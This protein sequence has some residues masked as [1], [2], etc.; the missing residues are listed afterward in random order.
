MSY[1]LKINEVNLTKNEIIRKWMISSVIH[2]T[3][4]KLLE[5]I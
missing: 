5:N 1:I 2:P 4:M 3:Q